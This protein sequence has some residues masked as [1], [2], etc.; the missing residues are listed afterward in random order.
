MFDTI[1]EIFSIVAPVFLVIGVGFFL[2]KIAGMDASASAGI[3][4]IV[5]YV[6][7]P[8]LLFHSIARSNFYNS[9]PLSAIGVIYTVS[10]LTATI[11]YLVSGLS[12][13]AD[14]GVISQ[15][16]YRSNMVF[17]GLPI[18]SNLFGSDSPIMATVSILIGLTVPL[19]NL[20]A[21]I[22]LTLS[23]TRGGRG[24]RYRTGILKDVLL[25]PLIL[26]SLLGIFWSIFR[27]PIPVPVDRALS[28]TGS[29]AAPLALI[30]VGL[31]LDFSFIME[32]VNLTMV[33]SFLKLAGYPTLIFLA[34]F[35]LQE[36]REIIVSTVILAASP[37]AVVSHIMAKEMGGDSHLSA[38]IVVATTLLSLFTISLWL[39]FF[40]FLS[41][42]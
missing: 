26:A 2:R 17:L 22:V 18:I 36:S 27:L 15:G 24:K 12:H 30:S 8:A 10:I 23:A 14:P 38:A 37:T 33:V 5:F 40:R 35:F 25:N 21:V 4:R 9:F 7:V 39:G 20:L 29:I 6:S 3:T 41:L 31:S 28:M 13:S 11:I 34:L 42:I 1:Y 32:R 19:Y 16:A